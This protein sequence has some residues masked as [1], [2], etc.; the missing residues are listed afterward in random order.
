[1]LILCDMKGKETTALTVTI[2]FTSIDAYG[3]ENKRE[4]FNE[5]PGTR[6]VKKQ[7]DQQPNSLVNN[8]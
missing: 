7:T 8:V 5:A 1:M 2:R 3:N 4:T 6:K